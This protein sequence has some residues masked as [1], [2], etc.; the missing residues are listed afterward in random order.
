M[1]YEKSMLHR[2]STSLSVY[3]VFGY[4]VPGSVFLGLI[5]AFD[6][7]ISNNTMLRP[8]DM[9]GWGV[10]LSHVEVAKPSTSVLTAFSELNTV[11]AGADD[12]VVLYSV[13]FVV[14]LLISVYTLGHLI[15]SISSL[16]L[17]RMLIRSG[18]GYPYS[19]LLGISNEW[20]N[21]TRF[22]MSVN[23]G[24]FFWLNS[25][26]L[27]IFISAWFHITSLLVRV[28]IIALICFL[29]IRIVVSIV[30]LSNCGI[31]GRIW[32]FYG[33]IQFLGI[34][35]VIFYILNKILRL[36]TSFSEQLV[37]RYNSIFEKRFNIPYRYQETSNFW[38]SYID[39]IERSPRLSTLAMNW[40]N[41][42]GFSRNMSTAFYLVYIYEGIR[43]YNNKE[44]FGMIYHAS[45]YRTCVILILI[46]ALGMLV[47]YY[48]LYSCYFTR[49]VFRAFISLEEF[50]QKAGVG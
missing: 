49:F 28:S 5:Y 41:L 26:L 18:H 33:V 38:F 14:A 45:I 10:A 15:A 27:S 2:V 34:Y 35:D 47:R 39:V 9:F 13:L 7:S 16:V 44:Y 20:K 24:L 23:R 37:E 4:V 31:N 32:K 3:D 8:I 25:A 40:R 36:E 30:I 42:Y 12:L 48:Y 22:S 46:S 50:E 1:E 29:I 43:I 19:H 17:D 11:L 6:F 21:V